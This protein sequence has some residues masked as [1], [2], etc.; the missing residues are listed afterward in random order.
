[1]VGYLAIFGAALAAY[2]GLGLWA[3]GA[4]GIALASISHFDHAHAHERGRELS[5]HGIIDSVVVRSMLNGMI[6]S[7]A[8]YGFGWLMRAI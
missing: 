6:A 2:A 5:L 1:M 8:A 4:S 3:I 7:G